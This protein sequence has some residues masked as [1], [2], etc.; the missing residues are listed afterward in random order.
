MILIKYPRIDLEEVFKNLRKSSG[1]IERIAE[2]FLIKK[3]DG[4]AVKSWRNHKESS[5]NLHRILKA[6]RI[7]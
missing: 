4:S 6:S 7:M 1:D 2:A 3:I 5:W